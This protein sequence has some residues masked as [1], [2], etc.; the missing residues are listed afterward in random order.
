[1]RVRIVYIS[2]VDRV[3][4]QSVYRKYGKCNKR[5]NTVLEDGIGE[6]LSINKEHCSMCSG[7]RIVKQMEVCFRNSQALCKQS[8][9]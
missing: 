7:K 5:A 1:M 4:A 8:R 6:I 9:A 2:H 3:L